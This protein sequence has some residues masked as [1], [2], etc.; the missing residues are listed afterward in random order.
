MMGAI[1]VS[2]L[3]NPALAY[4]GAYAGILLGIFY[5]IKVVQVFLNNMGIL[6][7]LQACKL[8]IKMLVKFNVKK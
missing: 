7:E 1:T 3:I 2:A 5:V 8:N 4:A 6:L